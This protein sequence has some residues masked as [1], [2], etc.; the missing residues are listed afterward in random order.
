MRT[1]KIHL[2]DALYTELAELA[3]TFSEEEFGPVR[4]ATEILTAELA[5]RR[6]PK[7]APPKYGARPRSGESWT[8]SLALSARELGTL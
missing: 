6:L 3:A 7:V 4:C 8:F 1:I 5:S 2:P